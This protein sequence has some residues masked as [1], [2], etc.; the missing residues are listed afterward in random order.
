MRQSPEQVSH[1]NFPFFLL[2]LRNVPAAL[3]LFCVLSIKMPRKR[4]D[5]KWCNVLARAQAEA[6]L[7]FETLS[8]SL[9][10]NSTQVS[11]DFRCLVFLFS[12]LQPSS[13]L[14]LFKNTVGSIPLFLSFLSLLPQFNPS[15]LL[16]P[17]FSRLSA[18]Q[19]PI[20]NA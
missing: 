7:F 10:S 11:C 1:R 20:S 8:A 14:T 19:T 2:F 13:N 4:K 15:T 3:L 9:I 16:R 17:I 12:L 6:D 5:S 18:L